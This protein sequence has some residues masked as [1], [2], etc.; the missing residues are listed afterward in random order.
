ME[1]ER[2]WLNDIPRIADDDWRGIFS[3]LWNEG[4]REEL[5]RI[6]DGLLASWYWTLRLSEFV[7]QNGGEPN[8][9][10]FKWSAVGLVLPHESDIGRFGVIKYVDSRLAEDAAVRSWEP[11]ELA[12][13]LFP[14]IERPI[15]ITLHAN[16]SIRIPRAGSVSQA[17]TR[18]G[19]PYE[20][21]GWLTAA[22]VVEGFSTVQ[23]EDGSTGA[24]TDVG[25]GCIDVALTHDPSLQLSM[26][27]RPIMQAVTMGLQCSFAGFSGGHPGHVTDVTTSLGVLTASALPVRVGL[28][29]YGTGGDSGSRVDAYNGAVIGNYLGSYDDASGNTAGLAQSA[30][31]LRVLVQAEYRG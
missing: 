2:R 27:H 10:G 16:R 31:Q 5:N 28:S 1:F 3:N 7:F 9:P 6:D 20:R 11:I 15:S 17:R 13:N 18:V 24:V 4:T 14:I 25:P 23:Y 8:V 21:E 12:D 26:H 22:H 30:N 19:T 29:Q